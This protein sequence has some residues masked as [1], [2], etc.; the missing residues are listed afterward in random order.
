[1]SE[2]RNLDY[3]KLDFPSDKLTLGAIRNAVPEKELGRTDFT[4]G[5]FTPRAENYVADILTIERMIASATFDRTLGQVTN[6]S[7]SDEERKDAVEQLAGLYTRFGIASG[8]HHADQQ[9]RGIESQ[10]AAEAR[11]LT[12]RGHG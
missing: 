5:V 2:T 12:G 6:N 4:Q 9:I 10:A 1:M 8:E 3:D 7:L 11:S